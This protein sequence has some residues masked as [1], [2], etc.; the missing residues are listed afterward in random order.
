MRLLPT[1]LA[2]TTLAASLQAQRSD[3][4]WDKAVAAGSTVAIHNITG[5][6]RVTPS[7]SGHVEVNGIKRGN[8]RYFDRIHAEVHE[9]SQGID[10]CV[11]YDNADS[12]CD[13][14][15]V[16]MHSNDDRDNGNASMDLEVAI[17]A[18]LGALSAGSVSGDVFVNG[19]RG[20]IN[21]N[22]VSGDVRLEHLRASAIT[23]HT[24]SGDVL[25]QADELT[26]RGDLSFKSVS[27]SVTLEVPRTFEAD[28]SMSTVS[29]D[30]DSDFA[31]TLGNGRMNRHNV[32][33]RI[34]N[35]G[36][37]LDVGTVSGDL[38]LRIIR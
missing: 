8:S 5:D 37:R 21:A 27:G 24:V 11:L 22:S 17:P 2:T 15:G 7:T 30:V 38:K 31:L 4:H 28:L 13:E 9:S 19:A 36:R 26:G 33:A 14:R 1:V 25:V 23:A 12:S 10:I 18:N 35:G 20:E 3:F 6:V 34:G 32:Q 16:H 29:G